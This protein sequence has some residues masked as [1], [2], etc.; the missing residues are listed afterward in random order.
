MSDHDVCPI[1]LDALAEDVFVQVCGHG[2]HFQCLRRFLKRDEAPACA[3]CMHGWTEEDQ[4]MFDKRL[5]LFDDTSDDDIPTDDVDHILSQFAMPP[6][7]GV[8]P[9]CCHEVG[10]LG[11]EF[12]L[13]NNRIMRHIA[14]TTSSGIVRA[15]ECLQCQRCISQD[16]LD[17]RSN[18]CSGAIGWNCP[19]ADHTDA[20]IIDLQTN[21]CSR[22][23]ARYCASGQV[24]IADECHRHIC[25]RWSAIL[26]VDDG[27]SIPDGQ[28]EQAEILDTQ[29]EPAEILNGQ[30]SETL[31][32]DDQGESLDEQPEILNGQPN[33]Q[34]PAEDEGM[35][36]FVE[37][38][39]K[40]K[41]DPLLDEVL[42]GI[43]YRSCDDSLQPIRKASRRV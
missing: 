29:P 12:T 11:D 24:H 10:F 21:D 31:L 43:L 26:V 6:P 33:G 23:C 19:H 35:A 41:E 30:H 13:L 2:Y 32:L 5:D 20:H 36:Q 18:A 34:P 4:D 1:C 17:R 25:N 7:I 9:T 3:V 14:S 38:I 27:N 42:T 15:W 40:M 28:P 39:T 8:I 16:D 37:E 22:G